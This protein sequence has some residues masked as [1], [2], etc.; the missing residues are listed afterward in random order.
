M[1][2]HMEYYPD[3]EQLNVPQNEGLMR[4]GGK[5]D[6]FLEWFLENKQ[7][8]ENLKY[9]WRGYERD[10]LGRWQMTQSSANNRILNDKGIHWGIGVMEN[11]LDRVFQSTNWNDEHMN[12]EM[13]KAYRVVWFGLMTQ[14]KVFGLSKVNTQGVAT[15]ILAR[16]HAMMLASRGEGIRRFIGTTQQISEQR[17]LNSNMNQGGGVFSGLRNVFKRNYQPT[18]QNN[19]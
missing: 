10:N 13:R 4:V 17:I 6:S 1:P 8:I 3:Q 2:Q 5:D 18:D 9:L 19:Y 12:Y 16:I 11:Y 15:Q 14:Y 7:G